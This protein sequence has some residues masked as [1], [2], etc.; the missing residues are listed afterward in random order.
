MSKVVTLTPGE[1]L[2]Y[3]PSVFQKEFHRVRREQ[4]YTNLLAH[5]RW[6][7]TEACLAELISGCLTC[8]L[9]LRK[10]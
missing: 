8:P 9:P 10:A 1:L 2:G 5:R 6:G 4:T 3:S 7:K